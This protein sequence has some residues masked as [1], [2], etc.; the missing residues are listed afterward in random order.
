MSDPAISKEDVSKRA[1]DLMNQ[2]L[3]LDAASVFRVGP[4]REKLPMGNYK[5]DSSLIDDWESMGLNAISHPSGV[6]DPDVYIGHIKLLALWNSFINENQDRLIRIDKSRS[7]DDVKASGKIG[8][9]IG[10]HHAD[11]FRTP[12]DV[13]YFYDL[14]LR[15]AILVLF[16]Q[17]RLGTAVDEPSGGGLTS[18][19]KQVI[20]RMNEVGMAVDVSHCNN[21][22]RLEAIEVS[23]KPVFFSHANPLGIC[24]N[25]RNVSDDVI[26]AT[27]ERGGVLGVM[28]LRMMVT[29][30]EPTTL[31]DY[32]NQFDYICDLV[33]PDYVGIGT[34]S[35]IEG[36]DTLSPE[37]S[38]PLPSYM[39]NEGVQ[40]KLDL[41]E[42]YGTGKFYAIT[43]RFV[44][45]NYS[46][47]NIGKILGANFERVMREIM[48]V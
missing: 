16:G 11:I 38:I 40:R 19:G 41:P 35:P 8:V 45:R 33:G 32:I 9:S 5:L 42:I 44:D 28:P 1:I 31:E 34:E 37:N 13:D 3:V 26:K 2:N 15:S 6:F 21:Q 20:K 17:N 30:N 43:D 47:E 25:T 18:Y 22:T 39:R 36:F 14:G 48:T 7:F 10:T 12:D 46:D 23:E 24:K 27:A 29:D 4:G